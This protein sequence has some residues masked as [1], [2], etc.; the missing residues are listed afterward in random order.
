MGPRAAQIVLGVLLAAGGLAVALFPVHTSMAID[1]EV[2]GVELEAAA[3]NC[4]MPAVAA[5]NPTYYRPFD[6]LGGSEEFRSLTAEIQR[7]ACPAPA[8]LRLGA[9]VL[10]ALAGVTI[11]VVAARR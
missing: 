10:F 7:E 9:G 2:G 5:F 11:A 3:V 8:R 4:G 1:R 6:D